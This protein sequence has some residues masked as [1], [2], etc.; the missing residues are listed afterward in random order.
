M[1]QEEFIWKHCERKKRYNSKKSAENNIKQLRKKKIIV[2][3]IGCYYCE[4]CGGWHIG[5]DRGFERENKGVE[6]DKKHIMA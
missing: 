6:N 1:T 4:F 3:K 2:G 5:H